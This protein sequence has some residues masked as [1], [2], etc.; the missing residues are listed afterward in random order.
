MKNIMAVVLLIVTIGIIGAAD[1]E[2]YQFID[3]LLGISEPGAPFIYEDTVIFTASSKFERVGIAF[4]YEGYSKLYWFK[5][6]MIPEDRALLLDAKGKM[7]KGV[8]PN[9]DSGILFHAQQIPPGARNLDYRMVI[10][11][12]WTR[13]PL[14]PLTAP[15][16]SG[17][18]QSRVPIPAVPRKPSTPDSPPLC[19]K[20]TYNAPPGETVTVGGSFN[21]WDPFMYELKETSP[22]VYTLDLSLPPGIYQYVFFHRG[23]RITDPYNPEKVYTSYGKP[24]SQA[25]VRKD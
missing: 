21:G 6:L 25:V 14:N 23:E 15:D 12:L 5:R 20:F 8:S 9:K 16:S 24:V 11:G 2:S 22:G 19:L 10:E 7:K 4:A 3:R 17:L 1:L 18:T 13:D